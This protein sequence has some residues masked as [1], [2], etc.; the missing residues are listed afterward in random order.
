MTHIVLKCRQ[1]II[2][3][4]FPTYSTLT[5]MDAPNLT[6]GPLCKR[7]LLQLPSPTPLDN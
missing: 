3:Q 5:S 1:S 7:S 4:Y 2:E 6:E